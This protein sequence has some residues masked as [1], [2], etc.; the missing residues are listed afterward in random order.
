[1]TFIS[2]DE[3]D[4]IKRIEDLDT[5]KEI[6]IVSNEGKTKLAIDYSFPKGEENK[7]FKVTTISGRVYEMKPYYTINYNSNASNANMQIDKSYGLIGENENFKSI[8]T[9]TGYTFYGWS[10]KQ[11]SIFA[12]YENIIYSKAN[13]ADIN[14]YAVWRKNKESVTAESFLKAIETIDET[15]QVNIKIQDKEESYDTDFMVHNGDLVLDGTTQIAE[16][17]LNDNTYEL[18]SPYVDV[19]QSEEES[20][21]AKNT[22]VLKVNGNLTI[23][24]NVKL[25][26]CKSE[27]GYGSSKGLIIYCTGTLTNNGD[28]SM[29]A[30]GAYAKG[31]D[32]YLWKN[33][34]NTYEYVPAI[35]ATGGDRISIEITSGGYNG[36]DG[37]SAEAQEIRRGTGGRRR[38]LCLFIYSMET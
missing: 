28:I 31:Q 36:K 35:G 11:S 9:R 8:P 13:D 22:I 33:S 14:L 4:K 24:E 34:N 25:T 30:R 38:R 27:N 7:S 2:K 10:E 37:N 18:G 19:A 1:M 12:E 5:G 6:N 16:A 15:C 21:M 3:E 26:T 32:I 17:T 29:T 20:G 23:N